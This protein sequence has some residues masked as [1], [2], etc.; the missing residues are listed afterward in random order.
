MDTGK[1]EEARRTY[2]LEEVM[3][4]RE[5]VMTLRGR[6]GDVFVKEKEISPS[7]SEAPPANPIDYAIKI[8]EETQ[9]VIKR[10]L[11]LIE[12]EIITKMIGR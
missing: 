7:E 12:V 8:S 9:Q 11:E 3:R 1:C 2:L 10:C 6:I 5:M 4:T